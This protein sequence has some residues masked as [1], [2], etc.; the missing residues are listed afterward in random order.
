MI[1]NSNPTSYDS[2]LNNLMKA[3]RSWARRRGMPEHGYSDL[4]DAVQDVLEHMTRYGMLNSEYVGQWALLRK[5][6]HQRL[7]R[8][9][10][11]AA[12]ESHGKDALQKGDVQFPSRTPSAS[13]E[14]LDSVCTALALVDDPVAFALLQIV[15]NPERYWDW[16]SKQSGECRDVSRESLKDF[17][18][19]TRR[20]IESASKRIKATMKQVDNQI[21]GS[22]RQPLKC[23]FSA[24]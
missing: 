16:A 17:T 10:Q 22:Q 21:G 9:K 19:T 6:A 13:P 15:I 8:L 14:L 23:E 12:Q 7:T 20:S 4:D 1:S 18:Q 2:F 11:L 5:T 24:K 3:V